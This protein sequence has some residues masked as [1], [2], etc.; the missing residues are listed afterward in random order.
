MSKF[1][2][3]RQETETK[4][5]ASKERKYIKKLTYGAALRGWSLVWILVKIMMRAT[6]VQ[7]TGAAEF[8]MAAPGTP[9]KL[10]QKQLGDFFGRL[11]SESHDRAAV[12]T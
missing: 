8:C 6:D 5:A 7:S 11:V 1:A 10:K 12:R 9:R 4:A 2:F 3:A